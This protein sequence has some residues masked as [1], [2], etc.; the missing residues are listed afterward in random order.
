MERSDVALFNF[1]I[2]AAV[3]LFSA[4]SF[5]FAAALAAL[6]AARFSATAAWF[7]GS[8]VRDLIPSD[9]PPPLPSAAFLLSASSL[10]RAALLPLLRP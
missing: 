8:Y 6:I 5:A 9:P 10:L 2:F 4:S 3:S 7:S 1:F